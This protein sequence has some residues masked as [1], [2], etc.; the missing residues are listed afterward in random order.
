MVIQ[1]FFFPGWVADLKVKQAESPTSLE[2][3]LNTT[4]EGTDYQFFIH[5]NGQ[6]VL[7]S[8]R[9]IR[10]PTLQFVDPDEVLVRDPGRRSYG[11]LKLPSKINLK[12]LQLP[13]S[14]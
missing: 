13:G 7:T 4:F 12:I 6:V 3:I 10:S 5:E 2:K 11:S 8:G 1:F 14:L 9:E